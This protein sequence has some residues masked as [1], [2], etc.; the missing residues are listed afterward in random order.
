VIEIIEYSQCTV[1]GF[2]VLFENFILNLTTHISCKNCFGKL[3][4]DGEDSVVA[5][6][7]QM[8]LDAID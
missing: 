8:H 5:T 1:H 6:C 4:K 2:W 3:L 7:S